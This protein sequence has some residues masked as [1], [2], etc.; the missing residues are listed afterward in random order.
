VDH[1]HV[2]VTKV[3][4]AKDIKTMVQQ[5]NDRV[6]PYEARSAR[7]QERGRVHG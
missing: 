1:I 4:D 2:A 6:G 5:L 3:I 7:D